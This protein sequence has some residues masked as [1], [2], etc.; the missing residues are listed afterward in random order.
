MRF[1]AVILLVCSPF[2]AATAQAQTSSFEP[3]PSVERNGVTYSRVRAPRTRVPYERLSELANRGVTDDANRITPEQLDAAN[4]C[5]VIF[6]C[7]RGAVRQMYRNGSCGENAASDPVTYDSFCPDGRPERW[8]IQGVPYDLPPARVLTG[9]E[10]AARIA[11]TIESAL[12]RPADSDQGAV[13]PSTL[14]E[15]NSALLRAVNAETPATPGQLS[16]PLHAMQRVFENG[17]IHA[18]PSA[19]PLP[20]TP[21]SG[22]PHQAHG[23]PMPG[24]SG[25]HGTSTPHGAS[26]TEAHDSVNPPPSGGESVDEASNGSGNHERKPTP[27]DTSESPPWYLYLMII[28]IGLL[29]AAVVL[30]SAGIMRLRKQ[31]KALRASAQSG[32]LHEPALDSG[33]SSADAAPAAL[34]RPAE[35]PPADQEINTEIVESFWLLRGLKDDPTAWSRAYGSIYKNLGHVLR[36][37]GKERSIRYVIQEA[38]PGVPYEIEAYRNFFAGEA[39]KKDELEKR[40]AAAE[41]RLAEACAYTGDGKATVMDHALIDDAML[42]ASEHIETLLARFEPFVQP[43]R[44]LQATGMKAHV[45]NDVLRGL[46]EDAHVIRGDIEHL[47]KL[48]APRAKR[49]PTNGAAA[50]SPGIGEGLA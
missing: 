18:E 6:V 38:F 10:E 22:A 14:A 28:V 43:G 49:A 31:I 21:H 40:L 30:L 34:G 36:T 27:Q 41:A 37:V 12:D 45:V 16:A 50:S 23:A 11:A 35:A 44:P 9:G 2:F 3:M 47:S 48:F 20:G 15:W 46:F 17:R 33:R 1:F 24:T 39:K 8:L 5:R 25:L 42:G 26:P 4:P 7:R 29:L 13:T 32:P 19:C